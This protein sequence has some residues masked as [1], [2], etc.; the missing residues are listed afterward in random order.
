MALICL[1]SFMDGIFQ[2]GSSAKIN[3]VNTSRT[4]QNGRHSRDKI[5]NLIALPESYYIL[6]K[7]LSEMYIEGS[8]API[9]TN[10]H[11]LSTI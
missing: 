8:H 6:M 7:S 1:I 2:C 10:F 3:Y 11:A 4:R 5:S 9:Y